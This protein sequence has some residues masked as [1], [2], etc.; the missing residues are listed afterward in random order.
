[1]LCPCL[2]I[3]GVRDLKPEFCLSINM[4]IR[5]AAYLVYESGGESAWNSLLLLYLSSLLH[6]RTKL[7][8]L[9]D[10]SLQSALS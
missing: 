6:H 4:Y 1:M 9:P 8:A 10:L 5:F 7:D 3:R 2:Y